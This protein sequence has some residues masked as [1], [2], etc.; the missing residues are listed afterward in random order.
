MLLD[1]S[2]V[3]SE[4]HKRSNRTVP[5]EMEDFVREE[6]IF[7]I[8]RKSTASVTGGVRG[9]AQASDHGESRV[10]RF[11][12]LRPVPDSCR[13]AAYGGFRKEGQPG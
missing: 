10:S 8:L 13:D 11:H 1:L 7:R 6:S 5:V 12:S 9:G 3:L 4:Q 2:C